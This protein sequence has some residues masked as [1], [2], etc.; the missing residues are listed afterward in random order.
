MHGFQGVTVVLRFVYRVDVDEQTILTE[1]AG[2]VS[3]A[4]ALC[5]YSRACISIGS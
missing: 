5:V 4:S 1:I 3:L 2:R